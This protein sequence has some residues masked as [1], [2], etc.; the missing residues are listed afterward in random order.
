MP[1]PSGTPVRRTRSLQPEPRHT[2]RQAKF[3]VWYKGGDDVNAKLGSLLSA[4]SARPSSSLIGTF[5]MVL[6]LVSHAL[7]GVGR[8]F[9]SFADGCT[10][11]SDRTHESRLIRFNAA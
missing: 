11:V 4:R 3:G 1:L 7:N 8:G 5:A 2:L 6:Q 9:G 10:G